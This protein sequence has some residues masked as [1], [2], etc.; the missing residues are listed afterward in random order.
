MFDVFCSA[1]EH[2]V[3]ELAVLQ[4]NDIRIL[5]QISSS[6]VLACGSL[7][8]WRCHWDNVDLSRRS[9]LGLFIRNILR[10]FHYPMTWLFCVFLLLVV[11]LSRTSCMPTLSAL[12]KYRLIVC[13]AGDAAESFFKQKSAL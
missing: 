9:I 3:D 8:A 7:F 12:T 13:I 1:C 4:G 5:I 10:S 6:H 2:I 11:L